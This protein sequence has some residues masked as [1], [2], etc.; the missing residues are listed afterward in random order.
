MFEQDFEPSVRPTVHVTNAVILRSARCFVPRAGTYISPSEPVWD[1]H[2]NLCSLAQ[3]QKLSHAG[4]RDMNREAELP[5]PSGVGSSARLCEN[6]DM[7]ETVYAPWW[8]SSSMNLV[9]GLDRSQPALAAE[10]C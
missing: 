1:C 7:V 4:P 3:R 5:A 2:G 8:S 10:I 6:A 9:R